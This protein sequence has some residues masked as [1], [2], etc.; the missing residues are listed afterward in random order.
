[1]AYADPDAVTQ[2]ANG[3]STSTFSYDNNGNLTQKTVDG[4]STTYVYDYANRLTALGVSGATTTYAYDAFGTRVL[5][6][7]TTTTSIYPFKWYSVASSTGTGAKYATTTDYVFN[8]DTLLSTVDQQTSSGVATGTAKTRYIHPDHLGSTNV[9]TDENDAVVQTLD[10]YPY[11][12]TR[13]SS[14]VGGTNSSRK[15]IGQFADQSNLDYLNARY[16]DP[17]RG[18]FIS[19]DPVFLGDPKDQLLANPQS[20][21]SYS[22]ANDNPITSKDPSGRQV[23]QSVSLALAAIALILSYIATVVLPHLGSIS[24]GS[25]DGSSGQIVQTLPASHPAQQTFSP[26]IYTGSSGGVQPGVSVTPLDTVAWPKINLSQDQA[27][28]DGGKATPNTANPGDKIQRQMKSRGWSQ[29]Q[30]EKAINSGQQVPATN[31]ANDNPA[32][33]YINSD[34][35]NRSLS[36]IRQ[37]KLSMWVDRASNTVLRAEMLYNDG[38][39]T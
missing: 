35:G 30:I 6:T 32:T 39:W 10:Y 4:T 20:L 29:D 17:S 31:K 28:S 37:E 7:G 18:Q 3:L 19:Q 12:A 34:T 11:G 36:T 25:I 2:I 16:Y 1:M 21:N 27:G 38:L 14:N 9:M 8:G 26:L 22:Y 13:I 23:A 24:Y 15:F 5:Q 33:R